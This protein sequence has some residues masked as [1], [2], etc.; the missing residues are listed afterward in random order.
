MI[1]LKFS[2]PGKP[3]PKERPRWDRRGFVFTPSKTHQYERH[4]GRSA[5]YARL[6]AEA[7]QPDW[8]WPDP[9]GCERVLAKRMRGKARG[10]KCACA[11]CKTPW[12]IAMAIYMPDRR[13]R[14]TDNVEKA[15][16]DGLTG[17]LWWDDKQAIVDRKSR[18]IDRKKPRVDVWVRQQMGE[19]EPAI[20]ETR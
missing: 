5:E 11:W 14:D 18:H 10:A 16:K 15:V 20:R 1:E 7:E 17:W 19:M 9:E 2:V 8:H 3:Q 13:T 12:L 6:L 4:V